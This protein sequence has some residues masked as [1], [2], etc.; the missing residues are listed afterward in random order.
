MT[1]MP[2]ILRSLALCC[3]LLVH[4]A[5]AHGQTVQV[6]GRGDAEHDR[7]LERLVTSGDYHVIARDTLLG[8]N[9]T[10][11]GTAL[12][13]GV[14]VRLEGVI[15][16]DLV[17]VDGNVFVRPTARIMGDVRNI[18]GGLYYSE[19][20]AVIGS[21]R[22]DPNAPYRVEHRDDGIVLIRGTTAHSVFVLAGFRGVLIPTYDRVDGLALSVGAGYMLPRIGDVEPV[23]RGRL[24]YRSQRGAFTGGVELA[25]ARRR[26]EVA[27][28]AERTTITNERWIRSDLNNSISAI[29]QGRDRRDYYAADRGYVELR[30]LL[31][32]GPRV[33][34]AFLRAQVEDAQSLAARNPWSLFGDFRRE[35][36]TVLESR[37]TS[38]GIGAGTVWTLPQQ[39]IEIAAAAELAGDLFD[40]AYSFARYEIDA[41]WAM[42]ALANHT[43]TIEPHVQGPLPGTDS[44][45]L[46]RWS[47]VG[48]S[49]TLYTFADAQFRGDRVAFVE[50]E[51]S[52]P[53][54]PR[55]RVRILGRPSLD[56][57]HSAGMAWT[58]GESPDLEQNVGIRLRFNMLYF[59]AITHPSRFID[60]AEFAV[61]VSF[62]RR[63][64][65]W[66]TAQ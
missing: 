21:V 54:P 12:V 14:T 36:I 22:S 37:I 27:V 62:P 38:A 51:Y 6:R 66:Q 39:F 17:I 5:A 15:A 59:R 33:T 43:L 49:G 25:A 3:A 7:Y 44:L 29:V 10:I 55:L 1:S 46:Q 20:A 50:T 35:N 28:G 45:P 11:P 65:P 53:L 47:F 24:D 42:A 23:V 52:I 18:A 30:R 48:G 13:L 31:E 41:T 16:G 64:Y 8:P 40:G 56:L 57:L 26:T 9:D 2:L 19:L 60:D 32:S 63:A 58:A 34:N 61:G 4:A